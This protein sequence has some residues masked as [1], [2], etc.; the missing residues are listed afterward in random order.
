M[1]EEATVVQARECVGVGQAI[2]FVVGAGKAGSIGRQHQIV[3]AETQTPDQPHEFAVITAQVQLQLLEDGVF[4]GEHGARD[5]GQGRSAF[6]S[7]KAKNRGALV[8]APSR[9][10]V[11]EATLI[12]HQLRQTLQQLY[13]SVDA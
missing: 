6:A 4:E 5:R 13:G 9:L 11:W 8:V 3:E 7:S 2:Q 1:Y 10:E 12:T